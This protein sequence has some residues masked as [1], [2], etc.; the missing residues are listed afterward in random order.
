MNDR[1][2]ATARTKWC[3][4][5]EMFHSLTLKDETR[6]VISLDVKHFMLCSGKEMFFGECFRMF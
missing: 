3:N 2:S 1:I 4:S 6:A 5:K